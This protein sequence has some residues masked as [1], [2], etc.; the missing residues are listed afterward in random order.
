MKYFWWDYICLITKL[1]FLCG[2]PVFCPDSRS[3]S[4]WEEYK[5][6]ETSLPRA[7]TR[8]AGGPPPG[9]W[10]WT[11]HLNLSQGRK[12]HMSSWG[13]CSG[14]PL[15]P[16]KWAL[17]TGTLRGSLE[18][19][20]RVLHAAPVVLWATHFSVGSGLEFHIRLPSEEKNKS[21]LPK[22]EGVRRKSLELVAEVPYVKTRKSELS[23]IRP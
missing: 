21:W 2:C 8:I 15:P 9:V 5:E 23:S 7:G 22:R 12:A 1:F 6:M 14:E 11:E 20:V 3:L 16:T 13:G 19:P 18:R 4:L 17:Q 10:V